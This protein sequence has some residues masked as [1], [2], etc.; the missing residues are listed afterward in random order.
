MNQITAK[1][2]AKVMSYGYLTMGKSGTWTWWP[3]KPYLNKEGSWEQRYNPKHKRYPTNL[4]EM[5]AIKKVEDY[6]MSLVKCGE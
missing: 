1:Q 5:F 6:T 4:D 3:S 2:V